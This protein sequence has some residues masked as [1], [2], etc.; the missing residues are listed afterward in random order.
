VGDSEPTK[1][2]RPAGF[3]G[4]GAINHRPP[5]R[6]F[7]FEKCAID[8]SLGKPRGGPRILSSDVVDR[9]SLSRLSST[10]GSGDDRGFKKCSTPSMSLNVSSEALPDEKSSGK[11]LR[12]M[13]CSAT[14]HPREFQ[15][16][17]ASINPA[18]RFEAGILKR[19]RTMKR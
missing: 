13:Q 11:M 3:Q 19:L 4:T 8:N 16:R 12:E 5:L 7:S 17:G 2:L 15:S 6:R 9:G 14:V 10:A 1:G 18:N